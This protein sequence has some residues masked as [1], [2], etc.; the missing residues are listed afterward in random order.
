MARCARVP[1]KA[2]AYGTKTSAKEASE[3]KL[4]RSAGRFEQDL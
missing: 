1:Q 2:S 3:K 4:A